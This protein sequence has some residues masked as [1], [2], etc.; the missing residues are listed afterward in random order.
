MKEIFLSI[1]FLLLLLSPIAQSIQSFE[2]NGVNDL[3]DQVPATIIDDELWCTLKEERDYFSDLDQKAII[4]FRIQVNPRQF[5]WNDFTSRKQAPFANEEVFSIS[6]AP[7][8][9]TAVL[10]CF[11]P[12]SKKHE[13]Y[14][15]KRTGELWG[16]LNKIQTL[17]D[18]FA[19]LHPFL[20]ETGDQLYFSAKADT[21]SWDIYFS[22]LVGGEWQEAQKVSGAVNSAKDEFYPVLRDGDLY[23]SSNNT[24]NGDFDV[25]LADKR[26][27]WRV[28]TPLNPPI[29]SS[30]NDL[31]IVFLS[32]ARFFVGSDRAG[33]YDVFSFEEQKE[34]PVLLKYTALLEVKG[35]PVPFSEV[36]VFNELNE[37]V[38]LDVTAEDGAFDLLNLRL[39]RSYKVRFNQLSERELEH[40]A[41]YI[42]N[43]KGDRIMVLRPGLD[44]F[45]L[46][47]VLPF[48]EM[49]QLAFVENIDESQLLTVKIEGT[50]NTED[51]LPSEKG[52]P[53]YIIDENGEL[54]EIAY[55][56]EGGKF[57]FDELTP[58]S[59]YRFRLDEKE[60]RFT[61]VVMDGD[62][63]V[64]IPIEAGEGF[65]ERVKDTEALRLI[66]EKGEP[67]VI[68]TS[69]RFIFQSIYFDFDQ[70]ELT[71]QAKEQLDLLVAILLKNPKLNINLSSHT[72][73]RGT[74]EYNLNLSKKR[75][76]STLNYLLAK[77][78]NNE[79]ISAVGRG[80]SELLNECSD[81]RDCTEDA[82]AVNRRTEIIFA[83]PN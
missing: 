35:V 63:E 31:N 15:C 5:S 40:A 83:V 24:S 53:I 3:K 77:G 20:S 60:K 34:V 57:K 50:L 1:S 82:H 38:V 80:E 58:S 19:C 6:Y 11:N 61:M 12:K 65:Y 30:A 72:D 54:L 18:E 29:N 47:E 37:R 7:L 81:E 28:L 76:V 71:A 21:G 51:N 52:L 4:N 36:E 42:L 14:S 13:L 55:T 46:F 56:R 69:E 75:A 74:T 44:G 66:N 62:K 64:E 48:D 25:F 45:F 32:D 39:R 49:E 9:S 70:F 16:E 33:N 73:S 79:R 22:N 27:Q 78:I 26:Q 43:E 59:S 68:R 2:L 17:G 10:S 41:L 8:D 23:I 67:I